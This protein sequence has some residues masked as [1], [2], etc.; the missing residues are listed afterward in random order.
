[1]SS[2]PGPTLSV[3]D[4]AARIRGRVD[5]ALPAASLHALCFCALA[6]SLAHPGGVLFP[7]SFHAGD[8][9]PLCP[10]LDA[11]TD[12][13]PQRMDAAQR[14]LVDAVID[15]H[16]AQPAER[17]AQMVRCDDP[18]REARALAAA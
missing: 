5:D 3:C 16:S 1:M 4:V 9:G 15:A 10:D 14:M 13:D 6:W 17:I 18:W 11:G 2:E 8:H 7:E 12:G